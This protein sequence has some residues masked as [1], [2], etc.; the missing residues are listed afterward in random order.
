MTD[1]AWFRLALRVLGLFFIGLSAPR[2]A[3]IV[4]QL[5]RMQ[6]DVGSRLWDFLEYGVASAM[7]PLLQLGFGLYL[8]FMGEALIRRCLAD[9]HDRCPACQYDIRATTTNLCP[10]CGTTL[11]PRRLTTPP[12]SPDGPSNPDPTAS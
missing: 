4:I 6:S 1:T 9:L 11:P 2:L 7:G 10:E 8:L 5:A 12:A 3:E